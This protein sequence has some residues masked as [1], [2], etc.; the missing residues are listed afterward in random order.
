MIKI[1]TS[2]IEKKIT[3]LANGIETA[4]ESAVEDIAY[5]AYSQIL[6]EANHGLSPE[7]A[8]AYI[9]GVE[10]EQFGPSSFAILL[11]S[12]AAKKIEEGSG[13]FNL[14]E[15]LLSS[16]ARVSQGSRAGQPWVQTSAKGQ[17]YAHVPMSRGGGAQATSSDLVSEIRNQVKKNRRSQGNAIKKAAQSN[18]PLGN[19]NSFKSGNP[20]I[21]DV[22]KYTTST[23]GGGEN[24]VFVAFKT[25]SDGSQGWQHPGTPGKYFIEAVEKWVEDEISSLI[26][27]L[28]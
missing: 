21:S 9:A 13:P 22:Q 28:S 2:G 5:G 25:V 17:R 24:D 12:D 8:E 26:S 3:G 1:D 14:K 6:A 4:I 27:D 10:I 7:D 20:L 15:V 11:T 16:S 19:P 23:P 18:N